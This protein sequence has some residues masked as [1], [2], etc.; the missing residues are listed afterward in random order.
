MIR[1][2]MLLW[3]CVCMMALAEFGTV[4]A[5]A[6]TGNGC[7]EIKG[8]YST[9]N[10]KYEWRF[11][12]ENGKTYRRLWDATNKKWVTDWILC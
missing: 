10:V 11:M 7:A 3:G 5:F 12:T 6:C 1:K 4:Q 2:K 8:D 9:L